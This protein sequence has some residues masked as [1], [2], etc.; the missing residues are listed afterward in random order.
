MQT[1]F[2]TGTTSR[3]Q[4]YHVLMDGLHVMSF[5]HFGDANRAAFDDLPGFHAFEPNGWQKGF[6]N[7]S[8]R[9]TVVNRE[10]R[11]VACYDLARGRL[12][13]PVDAVIGSMG[14]FLEALS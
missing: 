11:I 3:F 9:T 5:A 14:P 1:H 7:R 2:S 6:V 12:A 13:R 4:A 8:L 10:G